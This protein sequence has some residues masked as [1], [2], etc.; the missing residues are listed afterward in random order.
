MNYSIF[1]PFRGRMK[2]LSIALLL[3]AALTA[4][5]AA[6]AQDRPA[7]QE[8]WSIQQASVIVSAERLF[9][10]HAYS[11]SYEP[12]E[13]DATEYSG[14]MASLLY[15]QSVINSENDL[16]NPFAVPRIAVDGVLGRAWTVGGSI[17]FGATAGEV[18]DGSS[19]D[20]PRVVNFALH[21]RVGY[22]L[23]PRATLGVWLRAGPEFIRASYDDAGTEDVTEALA[24]TLDPQLVITPVPHA[25]I[26]LGPLINLG[27]WGRYERRPTRSEEIDYGIS[28]FGVTGGLA[29]FF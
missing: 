26:L 19:R 16:V 11:I 13:G 24:I 29:L 28:N 17:G 18:D 5:S 20:T 23:A 2:S 9:G 22:L 4:E 27:V 7:A 12:P 6:M 25:A 1:H 21:A 14:V 8:R 3:T 15:G 10:I